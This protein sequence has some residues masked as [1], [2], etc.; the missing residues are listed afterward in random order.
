MQTATVWLNPGNAKQQLPHSSTQ[1]PPLGVLLSIQT[2]AGTY[3]A[4]NGTVDE[5]KK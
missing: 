4:L 5:L 3:L 2:K 1:L